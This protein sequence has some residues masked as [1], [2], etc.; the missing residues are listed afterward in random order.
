VVNVLNEQT[1]IVRVDENAS[2]F[3]KFRLVFGSFVPWDGIWYWS[4]VQH[5]FGTITEDIIQRIQQEFPLKAP[6]IVYRYC[7]HLAEKAREIVSKHYRQ[8]MDYY[9]KDLLIYPDG[10]AMAAD[11]QKFHR[12]QFDSAPKEDI[13][14]FLNKHPLSELPPK[15]DLPPELLECHNGIGVY[16][17]P[18]EGQEIMSGFSEVISGFKK[19]GENLTEDEAEGIRSFIYSEDISPQFVNRLVQDYG[20]QSI[21]SAFLIP[22]ESDQHY[23]GYLL[24]RYK[25]HFYRNRYPSLTIV[26]H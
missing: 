17:N 16:F 9:G 3:Q 20:D 12:Y 8:F 23:L 4:G 25:G 13:E 10:R 2:Q 5:G 15:M 21:A 18:Q 26:D 24:R 22:R 6:Q 19:Q 7:G 11:M 14:A 1:Y